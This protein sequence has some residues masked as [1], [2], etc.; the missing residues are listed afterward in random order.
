MIFAVPAS[1]PEAKE[2]LTVSLNPYSALYLSSYD[3][4]R[5]MRSKVDSFEVTTEDEYVSVMKL[6][7]F[8]DIVSEGGSF[9]THPRH[10]SLRVFGSSGDKRWPMSLVNSVWN[11]KYPSCIGVSEDG[12]VYLMFVSE[13]SL[14][15]MSFAVLSEA[16]LETLLTMCNRPAPYRICLEADAMFDVLAGEEGMNHLRRNLFVDF[17]TGIRTKVSPATAYHD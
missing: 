1:S 7:F 3:S 8:E 14:E 5:R 16:Q 15:L 17:D 13:N 10:L 2:I 4:M 12:E 9:E 6:S 11:G